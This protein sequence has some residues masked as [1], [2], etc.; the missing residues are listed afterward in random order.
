MA[1]SSDS[2]EEVFHSVASFSEDGESVYFSDEKKD[3]QQTTN[4]LAQQ[5]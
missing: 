5:Q 1:R 2:R 4:L 3:N